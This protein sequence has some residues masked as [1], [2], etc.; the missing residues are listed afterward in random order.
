M[1]RNLSS[2]MTGTDVVAVQRLLNY[3]LTR[4]RFAPLAPDGIFGPLT[5]ARVIEFQTLNRLYPV[6]VPIQE[7]DGVVRKPLVIDGIVGPN[8]GRVLLDVRLISQHPTSRFTPTAE[9][10]AAGRAGRAGTVRQGAAPIGDPPTPPSPPPPKTIRFVTLQAGTQASVNP[11]VISPVVITGQFTWLARN[12]GKP[13][14]LLTAGGQ[15]AVNL[16][17]VNGRWSGQVFGQMG[18]GNLN[19]QLGPVDF[20]NPF[21][22]VMLQKNQDQPFGVGLAIGNQVNLSLKKT[23]INGIEQDRFSVFLNLQEAVTVGL[24]N[25]LCTAPATQGMLGLGWSFFL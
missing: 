24:D 13:D 23:T 16:G 19:L 20:V 1:P 3:H 25:G 14:F 10:Q 12:E 9:A 2:G 7:A 15:F 5:R 18:L 8:T 21:V 6:T 17:D 4:P 22:Q 11:W